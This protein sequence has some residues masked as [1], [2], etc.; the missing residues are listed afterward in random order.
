MNLWVGVGRIVK[1]PELRYTQSNKMV[2]TNTLAVNRRFRDEAGETQAD[3]IDVVFW[4]KKAELIS[5][6]I[7]KGHR[8]GVS[9]ELQSRT[10]QAND[11]NNRTVYEVIVDELTFLEPKPRTEEPVEEAKEQELEVGDVVDLGNTDVPF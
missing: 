4:G 6:Y 2:L 1:E 11:G 3:F 10:Y 7:K 9:G 5:K 8:L